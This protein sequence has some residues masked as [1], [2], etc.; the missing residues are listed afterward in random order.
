MKLNSLGLIAGAT[1]AVLPGVAAAQ[2]KSPPP[3]HA[4][5]AVM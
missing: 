1:L 2:P 5:R 3:Y 4:P